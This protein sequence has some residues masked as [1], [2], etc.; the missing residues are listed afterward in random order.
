MLL[1][2]W[3]LL[4]LSNLSSDTLLNRCF[5]LISSPRARQY[6]SKINKDMTTAIQLVSVN[7]DMIDQIPQTDTKEIEEETEDG[8]RKRMPRIIRQSFGESH[9]H[10]FD[11]DNDECEEH[12][13]VIVIG[14]DKTG[15]Q[16]S[17]EQLTAII[18]VEHAKKY[19]YD[20]M[21][22]SYLD[23]IEINLITK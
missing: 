4:I 11:V 7:N 9:K 14:L 22:R 3:D 19:G 15:Q 20:I 2:S 1:G 8:K 12:E 23:S 17:E 21:K 18:Q 16:P 13:Q 5:L 10:R 6:R